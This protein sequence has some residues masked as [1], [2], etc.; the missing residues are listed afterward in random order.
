MIN[1]NRYSG[2]RRRFTSRTARRQVCPTC[3]FEP[4][5]QDI[6]RSVM[7]AVRGISTLGTEMG[8]FS[9]GLLLLGIV[10]AARADLRGARRIHQNYFTP[11][12]FRF[13]R[14]YL[15]ELTPPGIH[16][17]FGQEAFREVADIQVLYCYY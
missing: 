2:L 7:I 1:T 5:E 15:D 12:F 17:V 6:T 4:Q 10:P 8:A 13:V 9:Q 14:Q 16:D 3:L 11:S